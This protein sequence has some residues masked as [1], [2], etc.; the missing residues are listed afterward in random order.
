MCPSKLLPLLAEPGTN[1]PV[2]FVVSEIAG[3]ERYS[4]TV[5]SES[6]MPVAALDKF[7]FDFTCVPPLDS[8]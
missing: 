5:F 6:G 3:N 1:R 2:N 7:R 8:I 4:G